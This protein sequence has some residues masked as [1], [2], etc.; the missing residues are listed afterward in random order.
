[1]VNK[2]TY[3]SIYLS[4][5]PQSCQQSKL[6]RITTLF[7]FHI[8]P[9]IMRR[10]HVFLIVVLKAFKAPATLPFLSR[11]LCVCRFTLNWATACV[12]PSDD[13]R[14]LHQHLGYGYTI[15]SMVPAPF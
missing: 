7:P 15:H 6:I 4:I 9:L 8:T 12:Q 13:V 10:K 14:S 11:Y 3:L 5:R 1:M 2:A